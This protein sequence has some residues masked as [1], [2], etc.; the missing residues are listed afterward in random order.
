M[1]KL[2][3]SG[4]GTFCSFGTTPGALS[5]PRCVAT[6]P[7]MPAA[8]VTDTVPY[9]NISPFGMCS[10]LSNP[11]VASA[12]A[13]AFGVLTPMPCTPLPIAPWAPGSTAVRV[14][15]LRV[16]TQNSKTTCAY[17]GVITL[18]SPGQITTRA[19]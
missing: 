2:V 19:R 8:K 6:T 3:C 16:L 10:S 14:T 12:T 11:A 13:A 9:L 18:T 4:A 5:V 17:G 1:A 7:A 15:G